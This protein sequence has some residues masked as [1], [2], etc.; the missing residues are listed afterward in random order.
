MNLSKK[1]R[2]L[3]DPIRVGVIGAGIFGSQVIHAIEATPGMETVAIADLE[4]GKAETTFHRT[5]VPSANI[6][7]V[8][9]GGEVTTIIDDGGRVVT[10]NSDAIITADVDVVVEATGDPNAAARNGFKTLLGGTHFVNVSVEADTVCGRLLARLAANN[11]VTYSLAYG[12]QPGRIADLCDWAVSTGFEVIATGKSAR[13][14]QPYGTP[15]DAVER[16]PYIE[17]FGGGLDPTPHIYN[18]FLDGTKTAVESV[19]AANA[20]NLGIDVRDMHQ[21]TIPIAEIPETFRPET[22]GGVLGQTGVVDAVTPE[23]RGF[24]VFVVTRTDS[25][26]LQEYY[27]QR[28]NIVTSEDGK[29]Q[30]F[31]QPYHFAPETTVSIA[32][33][34]LL[35]EPT[36][37]PTSHRAEVVAAA[38]R[39]LQ[40]GEAVDGGGGY[41]IYG[42]AEAA[43]RAAAAG[44]VP[45]ELLSG[46]EVISSIE[47]DEIITSADV[48]LDREQPLYHLRELQNALSDSPP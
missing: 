29:Y 47:Q 11:E 35:N 38:K 40:P 31:Y 20:L 33:A 9:A 44:Y 5:G 39:D 46:A 7:S 3:A 26:Q 10:R 14:P 23:D 13:E 24:S 48:E 37:G 17:S 34:A 32:T 15:D 30:L 41:T 36:G 27:A 16:H 2:D 21:P 22:D 45:F 4:I 6:T 25:T 42:V 18:T 19:A 28:A 1:L 8:Q 12:D 43:D